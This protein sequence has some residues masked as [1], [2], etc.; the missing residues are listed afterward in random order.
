MAEEHAFLESMGQAEVFQCRFGD[1][2]L[3]VVGV[4]ASS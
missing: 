2:C 4:P 1:L 3:T